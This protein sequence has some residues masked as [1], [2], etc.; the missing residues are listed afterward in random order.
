MRV[1][2]SCAGCV[3]VGEGPRKPRQEA[4]AES[5]GARRGGRVRGEG[6]VLLDH[7]GLSRQE[8]A[9]CF[10]GRRRR[11]SRRAG[12][13][14]AFGERT[15][16]GVVQTTQG[17]ACDYGVFANISVRRRLIG[18]FFVRRRARVRFAQN[19]SRFAICSTSANQF[20]P[21]DH[22]VPFQ[23]S[24]ERSFVPCAPVFS[25]PPSIGFRV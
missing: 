9:P 25:I 22:L 24:P 18:I 7:Q 10:P 19:T 14:R 23:R 17:T 16:V 20:I 4:G 11:G 3:A 1:R 12:C 2:R 6:G 8:V 5:P 15:G 21:D 13:E